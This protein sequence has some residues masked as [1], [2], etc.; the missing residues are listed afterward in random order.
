VLE[1][2]FYEV[3]VVSVRG[4]RVPSSFGMKVDTEC[5]TDATFDTLLVGSAPDVRGFAHRKLIS[6]LRGVLP[7]KRGELL[8]SCIG[9]FILGE[10]G[11]LDGPPRDNSLALR[12]RASNAA[13]R[14]F[15]WKRIGYLSLMARS[16]LQ[17]E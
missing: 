13:I 9:A 4:R 3:H 16:G 6:F 7:K 12:E 15:R 14:R 10:A 8:R 11:L 5:A 2:P 1:K 17:L